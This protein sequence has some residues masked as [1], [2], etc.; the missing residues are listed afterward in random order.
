M[1]VTKFPKGRVLTALN[2]E[3]TTAA[4]SIDTIKIDRRQ[5]TLAVFRQLC[6]EDI[7]DWDAMALRGVGWGWTNYL[8]DEHASPKRAIHI[9]WQRGS[10]LRRCVVYRKIQGFGSR[11]TSES[12]QRFLDSVVSESERY[13]GPEAGK[14]LGA[15]CISTPLGERRPEGVDVARHFPN[16]EGKSF[17]E[18]YPKGDAVAYRESYREWQ[19]RQGAHWSRQ[20]AL[21]EAYHQRRAAAMTAY[22]EEVR[23]KYAELIDFWERRHDEY[24]ALVAPLFDLPQLFIAV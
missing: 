2:A 10:E 11:Y 5:V 12:R 23:A 13:D 18:P 8:I 17:L 15:K 4:V 21:R 9:V 3:V 22:R 14:Y 16:Y 6:I 20:A 19:A 1:T 24:E 7:F